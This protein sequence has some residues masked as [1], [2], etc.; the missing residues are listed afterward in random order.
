MPLEEGCETVCG[1][2]GLTGEDLVAKLSQDEE[3]VVSRWHT[4]WRGVCPIR[5]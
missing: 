1:C 5:L 4:H 3:E 2:E